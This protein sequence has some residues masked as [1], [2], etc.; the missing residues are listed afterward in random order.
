M[1]LA[2]VTNIPTPY[3]E[4]FFTA[5][6][7]VA[8]DR[9]GRFAVLY[10]AEG[11]RRRSEWTFVRGDYERVIL[12][13]RVVEGGQRSLH[14][15]AGVCPSLDDVNPDVVL[16]GGWDQPAFWTARRWTLRNR[17]AFVPWVE[18]HDRSSQFRGRASRTVRTLFLAKARAAMVPSAEARAYLQSLAPALRTVVQ[19][20]PVAPPLKTHLAKP[21]EAGLVRM[22]FVGA[23][24]E[25]KDPGLL[26]DVVQHMSSSGISASVLFAGSGPLEGHLR[27]RAKDAQV[28]AAFTGFVEGSELEKAWRWA[29]CLVLPSMRDPAPLVLSEAAARGVPFVASDA[30]GGATTLVCFGASGAVVNRAEQVGRWAAAVVSMSRTSARQVEVVLPDVAATRVWQELAC[31]VD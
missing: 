4:P 12:R 30:C 19:P 17:R 23:L 9:S 31:L 7:R 2:V 10:L 20:N 25:R 1:R 5:L 22:L 13:G 24:I 11:L 21:E 8:T 29:S 27:Q 26:V 15:N 18:S 3:R 16:V 6:N 14:L 28:D